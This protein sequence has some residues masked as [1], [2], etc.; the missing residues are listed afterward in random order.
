M[1][2]GKRKI[3]IITTIVLIILIIAA[4]SLYLFFFTD[5][6]KGNQELFLKYLAQN[7][8]IIQ[9]FMKDSTTEAVNNIK[10]NKYTTNSETTFDLVSSDMEIAN[11]TIPARNFSIEHELKAD[12]SNNRESSQTTLKFLTQDLFTLKYI[13]NDDLYAITSDEVVNKYLAFDNNNLKDLAGKFGI[14]DTSNI[15]NRIE[16]I[17][18]EELLYINDEDKTAIIQKYL[19]VINTQIPK[20][21]YTKERDV[22]LTVNNQNIVA[23]G[24]SLEL[25]SSELMNVIIQILQTLKTDDTTLNL[26]LEKVRLIDSQSDITKETLISKIDEQINALNQNQTNQFENIKITVYESEGQLIRTELEVDSNKTIVDYQKTETAV[27]TLITLENNN[28]NMEDNDSLLEENQTNNINNTI[29][30]EY[31]I[32]GDENQSN[33]N[34]ETTQQAK[35]NL[36]SIE[37]AKETQ[38]N[39]T[40]MVGI[41][42]FDTGKDSVTVSLQ[43]KTNVTDSI[44]NN[45][46]FNVN[47]SGETYFK[48][49]INS[50][51]TVT[52]DIEVKELT[53]E[54]SATVNNFT[55]EYISR[56]TQDIINR[57]NQLYE[58]K[59]QIVNT[60]QQQS[61]Q[62]NAQTNQEEQQG[63]TTIQETNNNTIIN[64]TIT[65]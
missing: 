9:M 25:T 10:Q 39:Q 44:Q 59:L 56:L 40:N 43:N 5:M 15:P 63:N 16:A 31:Q 38:N 64:N 8:E 20:E 22:Q 37:L 47:I 34:N 46:I 58:Q 42:V 4:I 62:T 7:D 30:D 3:F 48:T 23:N 53:Q 13:R 61:E 65:N 45:I 41:L 19:Q 57:L 50:N 36:K 26:I 6:F 35:M 51:T 17:N 55:P 49:T 33:S 29:N 14:T 52:N 2:S 27:R 12:P 11:Q 32:I 60:V 28:T 18:L 21:K 24:Y 1:K 54:N